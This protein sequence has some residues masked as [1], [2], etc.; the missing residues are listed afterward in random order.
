[1]EQ[2]SRQSHP[3]LIRPNRI[4][5]EPKLFIPGNSIRPKWLPPVLHGN[6]STARACVARLIPSTFSGCYSRGSNGFLLRVSKS[7]RQQRH[8]I[9][10]VQIVRGFNPSP[11]PSD[12][13]R[14]HIALQSVRNSLKLII[15]G[16]QNQVEVLE[17]C[18][19]TPF[20]RSPSE[21]VGSRISRRRPEPPQRANVAQLFPSP[22]AARSSLKSPLSVIVHQ[23]YPAT[24]IAAAETI[25][26]PPFRSP[27]P[28][29]FPIRR[30]QFFESPV[31]NGPHKEDGAFI[32]SHG[33]VGTSFLFPACRQIQSYAHD[34]RRPRIKLPSAHFRTTHPSVRAPALAPISPASRTK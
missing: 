29:H 3:S 25:R 27:T 8:P 23:A 16:K 26:I 1:M 17:F 24:P 10:L 28:A 33:A 7:P 12:S 11:T 30:L 6:G 31:V 9:S 5:A 18:R 21:I 22:T 32:I 19:T 34:L 13:G 20:T 14:Q 2:Q 4:H 15:C